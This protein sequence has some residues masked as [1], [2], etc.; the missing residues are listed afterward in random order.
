VNR[1]P[2]RMAAFFTAVLRAP[3]TDIKLVVEL[4]GNFT[5]LLPMLAACSFAMLGPTLVKN[6]PIYNLIKLK[7]AIRMT[8]VRPQK[9]SVKPSVSE[10]SRVKANSERLY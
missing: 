6:P 4:T 8:P 2:T 1:N 7:N 9:P 3:L 10:L 5:Q